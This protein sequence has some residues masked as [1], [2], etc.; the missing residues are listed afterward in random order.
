MLLQDHD[1]L[2]GAS[3]ALKGG[4]PLK[5]LFCRT[6]GRILTVIWYWAEPE[7]GVS[8]SRSECHDPTWCRLDFPALQ[9]MQLASLLCLLTV[10]MVIPTERAKSSFP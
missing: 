1:H 7:P 8:Y 9:C 4:V 6:G 5:S 2:F 10:C 3:A